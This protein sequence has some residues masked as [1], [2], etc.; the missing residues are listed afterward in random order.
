MKS[1]DI[2]GIWLYQEIAFLT[3]N[4]S[5]LGTVQISLGELAV[6]TG[7]CIPISNQKSGSRSG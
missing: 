3:E 1:T 4:H 2:G 5:H 6:Y 7:T